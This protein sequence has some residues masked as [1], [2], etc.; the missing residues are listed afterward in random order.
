MAPFDESVNHSDPVRRKTKWKVSEAKLLL[1]GLCALWLSVVEPVNAK[2]FGRRSCAFPI[3]PGSNACQSQAEC[4]PHAICDYPN[5]AMPHGICMCRSGYVAVA[6]N[7][8]KE[9][10]TIAEK[11]GDSCLYDIQ[12]HERFSTESECRGGRCSCKFGSHHVPKSN[13]CYKSVRI[14][15]FCRLTNN[16]IGEGT[17]CQRGVCT[18]PYKTHPNEESTECI[19]DRQLDENCSSDMECVVEASRC[20]DTVGV[21]RCAADYVISEN[22]SNCLRVADRLYENCDEVGQCVRIPHS[23]CDTQSD[24]DQGGFCQCKTGFHNV[25]HTCFVTVE[26]GGFCERNENCEKS[27]GAVCKSGRCVCDDDYPE[28]DGY[29]MSAYRNNGAES[30]GALRNLLLVVINLFLFRLGLH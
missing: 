17:L 12:C 13:V 28:V 7:D 26:L 22:R 19:P 25:N 9:C 27:A 24:P 20:D 16:C 8:T 18:C 2:E 1:I 4:P 29:C 23:F 10:H 6:E 30:E 3:P 11:L 14:G 15:E 5:P 21:C